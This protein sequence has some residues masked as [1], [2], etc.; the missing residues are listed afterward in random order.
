MLNTGSSLWGVRVR[1]AIYAKGPE[2]ERQVELIA[3]DGP[4]NRPDFTTHFHLGRVPTL[5]VGE[6]FVLQES[7]AIM[8]F[9]DELQ[10]E[11]PLKPRDIFAR[12][13]MRMLVRLTDD[14]IASSLRPL[15]ANRDPRT[16]DAKAASQALARL[17]AGFD[18]LEY[19][20]EGG[21]FAVGSYLTLADCTLVPALWL[22]QEFLPYFDAPLPLATR[23]TCAA[24]WAAIQQDPIVSRIIPEMREH[25]YAARAARLADEEARATSGER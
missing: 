22:T 1:M 12:A 16:R 13:R 24:Y 11:P 14:G 8:E 15:F 18:R 25:L 3:P 23:P 6:D 7:E 4:V 19:F 10:P 9:V 21:P 17:A 5:W 2:F 20:I